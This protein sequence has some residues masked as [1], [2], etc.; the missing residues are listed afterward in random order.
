MICLSFYRWFFL[1][2]LVFLSSISLWFRQTLFGFD[3]YATLSAVRFGWFDHLFNQ[4]VANI[5]WRFLPD[6]LL[7]FN[8]IMFFSLFLSV[9]AIFLLVKHFFEERSAWLS[10]F[11]LLGLSPLLLFSFGEFENE[12]LAYPFIVWSIYLILT[13]KNR[14]LGYLLLF[15][16]SLFWF[17]PFYFSFINSGCSNCAV[18]QSLFAGLLNLWFLLPFLFVIPLLKGNLRWFGLL[19]LFGWLWNA[20]LF[21]FL[22]PFVA[23]AIPKLFELLKNH[24]TLQKSIT[25]LAFFGLFAWNVAFLLQSPSVSDWENIDKVVELSKDTNLSIY[26]DWSYG[27]WFWSRGIKT[28]YNPGSGLNPPK[29]Y[30]IIPGRWLALPGIYLTENEMPACVLISEKKEIARKKTNIWQCN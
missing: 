20:K 22:I 14:F 13:Q 16:G 2:V 11:C 10:V 23:L 1:F 6:S 25:Y 9:V 21:I 12:I 27:Y 17:W 30:E 29:S 28:P 8:S 4:P 7:V 19:A 5:V 26:N 18:E 15:V 3:S 24:E